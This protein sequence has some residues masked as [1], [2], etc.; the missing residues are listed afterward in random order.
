MSH[1]DRNNIITD[2]QCDVSQRR[3]ADL[4]L[5]L[6]LNEKGQTGFRIS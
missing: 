4:Q 2:A 5:Y 3:S 1:L 6:C